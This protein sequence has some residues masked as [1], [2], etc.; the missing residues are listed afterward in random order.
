MRLPGAGKRNEA[1]GHE[2]KSLGNS[3]HADGNGLILKVR[4]NSS[5]WIQRT[6]VDGK[7]IE[8]S[9]GTYL[10]ITLADLIVLAF[11]ARRSDLKGDG[12]SGRWMSPLANHII[13][14]LGD[15]NANGTRSV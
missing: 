6:T 14:K 1:D 8:M 3:K 4:G 2:N 10:A 15:R 7:R 9:I 11:E 12:A 13:P 5:G